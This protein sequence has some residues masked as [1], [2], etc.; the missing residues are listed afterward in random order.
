M[1]EMII[2]CYL[3]GSIYKHHLE[4]CLISKDKGFQLTLYD[5]GIHLG[6]QW[7][8]HLCNPTPIKSL[9]CQTSFW[10]IATFSRIYI[11]DQNYNRTIQGK[12]LELY[13]HYLYSTSIVNNWYHFA[14]LFKIFVIAKYFLNLLFQRQIVILNH[15]N[16]NEF[17]ID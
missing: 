14:E 4:L 10:H 9:G 12:N 17:Y 16:G 3:R 15:F 8:N 11:S 13:T 2:L 6:R 7:Q 5:Y 1:F